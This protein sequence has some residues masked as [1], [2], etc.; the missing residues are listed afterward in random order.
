MRFYYGSDLKEI[1]QNEKL[2]PE[3]EYEVFWFRELH[4]CKEDFGKSYKIIQMLDIPE[5]IIF[6]DYDI[7]LLIDICQKIMQDNIAEEM[8]ESYCEWHEKPN[9]YKKAF[10]EVTDLTINVTKMCKHA[11]DNNLEIILM[12]DFDND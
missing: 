10:N 7:N 8:V 5:P 4:G 2:K 3:L 9:L 12:P 6:D 11:L 1:E